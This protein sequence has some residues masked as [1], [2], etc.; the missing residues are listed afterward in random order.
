MDANSL[1][2]DGDRG[3]GGFT[4]GDMGGDRVAGVIIDELEDH[5]LTTAGKDVAG[6]V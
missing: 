5:A 1:V 4:P 6:G 2:E 3:L